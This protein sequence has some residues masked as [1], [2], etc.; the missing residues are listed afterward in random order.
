M[1]VYV[2]I[3]N[4]AEMSPYIMLAYC[5]VGFLDI[6]QNQSHFLMVSV[7]EYFKCKTAKKEKREILTPTV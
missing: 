2:F 6:S 1:C 7:K 3:K 4:T 5:S